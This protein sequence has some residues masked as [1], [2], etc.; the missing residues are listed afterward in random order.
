MQAYD[1]GDDGD[2]RISLSST[3][4]YFVSIEPF[5]FNSPKI[6]YPLADA[7]IRLE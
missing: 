7:T 5:N 6:I 3:A 2:S 4:T 1:H